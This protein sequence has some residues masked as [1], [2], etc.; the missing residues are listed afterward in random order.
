MMMAMMMIMMV[1]MIPTFTVKRPDVP[2]WAICGLVKM[3]M[4]TGIWWWL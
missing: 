1:M 3:M 4:V 2:L